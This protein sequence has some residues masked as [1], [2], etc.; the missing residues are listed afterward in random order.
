MGAGM[1][2]FAA[3]RMSH[4]FEQQLRNGSFREASCSNCH[5]LGLECKL[6]Q[7]LTL[8]ESHVKR[9]NALDSAS[10]RT[11]DD[12]ELL[13]NLGLA[14][15]QTSALGGPRSRWPVPAGLLGSLPIVDH[16]T[17]CN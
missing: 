5:S 8:E 9:G 4:E 15:L 3:S 1:P 6:R 14:R 13:T 7:W 10:N 12:A 17:P 2:G 16:H 11:R